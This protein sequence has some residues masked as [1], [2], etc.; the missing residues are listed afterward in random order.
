MLKAVITELLLMVLEPEADKETLLLIKV[1]LPV[2]F[3]V[4]L[5][6]V[7]ELMFC[8]SVAN[9]FD[10]YVWLDDAAVE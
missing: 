1:I 10:I 6:N 3:K 2:V 9:V 4:R 5:V 7:L 8:E